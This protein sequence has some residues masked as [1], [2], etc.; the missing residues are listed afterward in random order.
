[1]R[2]GAYKSLDVNAGM[3]MGLRRRATAEPQ[4]KSSLP[5]GRR[6]VDLSQSTTAYPRIDR[7]RTT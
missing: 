7:E 3:Y 2:A 5:E 6:S 1:M 4:S